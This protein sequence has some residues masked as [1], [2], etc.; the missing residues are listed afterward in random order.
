MACLARTVLTIAIR[1]RCL[2]E[3]R[4]RHLSTGLWPP[5]QSP[6]TRPGR[7]VWSTSGAAPWSFGNARAAAL[8]AQVSEHRK[9]P[10][11]ALLKPGRPAGRISRRLRPTG[12]FPMNRIALTLHLTKRCARLL[13]PGALLLAATLCSA[14]KARA[15]GWLFRP[16]TYS[17]DPVSGRRVNQYRTTCKAAIAIFAW[18]SGARAEASTRPTSSRPGARASGFGRM[19][20]G[21]FPS[22]RAPRL[23]ARGAIPRA[24]GPCRST[25]G[26]TPM[27]FG[28]HIGT[29]TRTRFPMVRGATGPARSAGGT[30]GR[31][32]MG[33]VGT[34][35][36]DMGRVDM[37]QVD[38]DQAGTARVDMA[39]VDTVTED[40]AL[41]GPARVDLEVMVPADP[42]QVAPAGLVRAGVVGRMAR[43]APVTGLD[44]FGPSRLVIGIQ[45]LS[46]N[47]SH[48][49][50]ERGPLRRKRL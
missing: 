28:T 32:D 46:Q 5:G 13:A 23:M 20:N 21:C 50:G 7:F 18:V 44:R 26:T 19:A 24:R 12:C 37:G 15:D 33:R 39:L 45:A 22:A 27:G 34:V 49:R 2:S 36:A 4:L 42:G 6:E 25:P 31:A 41:V 48:A 30:P 11:G 43:A 10:I 14:S 1:R 3:R 35:L 17:H 9:G 16:S 38:P 8:F 29:H 40:T 47:G